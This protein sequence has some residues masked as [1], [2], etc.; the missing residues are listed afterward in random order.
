MATQ[1]DLGIENPYALD[2]EQFD[3]AI[4]LLKE[5][6]GLLS[7]YWSDYVA[8]E[9]NFR[10]GS[11]VMGTSWEI[12]TRTLQADDP[13][14]PVASV[15]PEEGSTA[16]SDN[17]MIHAEAEHPNCAYL[18][19]NHITSP[20]VQ[21]EQSLHLRR[22]TGQPGRLRDGRPSTVSSTTPRTRSTTSSCTTGRHP[23]RSASTGAP[24]W[25]ARTTP[26]GST[27]WTEVKG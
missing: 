5:Q 11:T 9:D 26:S 14:T 20:E 27:A 16:W 24:T 19:I 2:E 4:D 22:G 13:P 8:Y 18:W 12:I 7:E 1:P 21:A 17:W 23:P 10:A 25:S 3:A 6:S 15:L